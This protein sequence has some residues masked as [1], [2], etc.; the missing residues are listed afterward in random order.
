MKRIYFSER[1]T[2]RERQIF[3][4][5]FTLH[6]AAFARVGPAGNHNPGA[7]E[8]PMWLAWRESWS[9]NQCPFGMLV[10]Q[11]A[12]SYTTHYST[13]LTLTLSL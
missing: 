10:S 11:G 6:M 4:C 5:W 9:S 1:V 8:P 2:E 12:A 13:M 3:F 7:S